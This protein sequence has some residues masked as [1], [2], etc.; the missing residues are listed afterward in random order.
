MISSTITT[1]QAIPLH[2][3]EDSLQQLKK[4]SGSVINY[5]HNASGMRTSKT[6]GG[7]MTLYFYDGDILVGE[8]SPT[9]LTVYLYS[10]DGGI[11][12]MQMPPLSSDKTLNTYNQIWSPGRN[13]LR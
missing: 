10:P 4:G 5:E 8:M 1:A 6:V 2:G 11:A 7:A 3:T 12:G 9:N 13:Y